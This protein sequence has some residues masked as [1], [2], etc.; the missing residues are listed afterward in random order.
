MGQDVA[1]IDPLTALAMAGKVM[2]KKR[3][4]VEMEERK[5]E[6]ACRPSVTC[7]ATNSRQ[8]VSVR[9]LHKT[10]PNYSVLCGEAG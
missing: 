9:G 5:K 6:K 10:S 2:E 8:F 4:N 1:L 7:V 3:K